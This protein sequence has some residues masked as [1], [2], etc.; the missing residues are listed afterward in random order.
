M[1]NETSNFYSR[2]STYDLAGHRTRL[3]HGDGFYVDYDYLVTGD[4]AHVR[5]NGA[6][7]GVGVLATY[8]YD[9]L[10]RRT[11][12]TRGN[13][14][15]TSYS[16]DAVSRLSQL[17]ED[18]SGTTYDQTLGFTYTPASQIA[19]NTRSNDN[20]AWGGHYNVSKSYTANG[21]NQYTAADS[22]SPTYD[23]RGNLTSAG[24]TTFAYT[25]ENRLA[26]YGSTL[27]AYDPL[28]RLH[29]YP[30]ATL[31][32]MYDGDHLLAELNA[33]N[34]AQVVRRYVYGADENEPLVWY[35]GS[36]TTDRR[37]LHEDER[38]SVVAVTNSPGGT[39]T[40]NSY[41]EKGVPAATNAG[42]FQYTVQA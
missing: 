41:D 1:T 33:S 15:S 3:T 14:T 17:S 25:S 28:G 8:A 18:I 42:R 16:Y 13:G 9:D 12:V 22:A 35:E 20:Y 29:Y 36:G 40:I 34:T 37:F 19:T 38:G 39:L 2:T 26:S 23:S 10:G 4:M 32:W 27:L 31:A 7:S 21:L 6:T 11:S 30:G 24:S 5:E